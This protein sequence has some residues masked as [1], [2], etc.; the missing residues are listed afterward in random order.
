MQIIFNNRQSKQLDVKEIDSLWFLSEF[1]MSTQIKKVRVL[2]F[3]QPV[4]KQLFQM[5][6]HQQMESDGAQAGT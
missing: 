2:E 6:T 4:G 3:T 5:L 1:I